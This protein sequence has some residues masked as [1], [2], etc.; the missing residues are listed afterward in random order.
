MD[1][2]DKAFIFLMDYP[3]R[4][5]IKIWGTA[6]VVEGDEGLLAHVT[7]RSSSGRPERVFL[8]HVAAW[9]VNCPQHIRPR[10]TE[11]ELP[12]LAAQLAD[13]VRQLEQEN[14]RLRQQLAAGEGRQGTPS[15]SQHADCQ[16]ATQS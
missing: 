15:A 4:K 16:L 5:R 2:N 12:P 6:E 8:F 3:R 14:V 9:D 7:D 1:E 13:R 11:E 10:W